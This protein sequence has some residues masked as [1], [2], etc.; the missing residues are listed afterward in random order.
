MLTDQ[1]LIKAARAF[2]DVACSG[3]TVNQGVAAMRAALPAQ[4]DHKG[5]IA[6]LQKCLRDAG[7]CADGGKCHHRCK[8]GDE[9]FRAGCC[10]P[11]TGSTLTNDWQVPS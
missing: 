6:W 4:P 8:P 11:L 2:M 9:C 1:D 7:H 10:E 5:A 3:G